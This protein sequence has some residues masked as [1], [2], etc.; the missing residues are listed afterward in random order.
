M[1]YGNGKNSLENF[2][3]TTIDNK[4]ITIYNKTTMNNKI[5]MIYNKITMGNRNVMMY[6]NFRNLKKMYRKRR[7][8]PYGSRRIS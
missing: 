7:D 3:K 5:I 2:A 4:N 6:N 8:H 1:G